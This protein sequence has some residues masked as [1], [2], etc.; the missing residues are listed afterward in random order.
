M[1]RALASD[2][3]PLLNWSKIGAA[4]LPTTLLGYGITDAVRN[5][6]G[7]VGIGTDSP[8]ASLDLGA[9]TDAVILAQGTTAQQPTSPVEG[10]FRYNKTSKRPEFFDGT[11]WVTIGGVSQPYSP[12]CGL[13]G[14][15]SSQQLSTITISA[16][17]SVQFKAW[18]AGGARPTDRAGVAGGNG[19]GGGFATVTIGPHSVDTTYYISIGGGGRTNSGSTP[20]PGGSGLTSYTGGSGSGP[21]GYGDPGA[22]GGASTAI[23]TGS[24][25]G[26]VVLVGAGGGG[27]GG[28][29][30]AYGDTTP[31]RPGIAGGTP[32]GTYVT[33]TAGGNGT[34]PGG[35]GGGT[36]GGGSG[37]TQGGA[38]GS[39]DGNG[40]GN[41]GFGGMNYAQSGG[42][43]SAG[44]GSMPGSYGDPSRP[45]NAGEGATT[46]ASSGRD[47]AIWYQSY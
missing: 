33:G 8:K 17:C 32:G 46:A 14:S 11:Q 6:G 16:G 35:F 43:V 21:G 37:Y 13:T 7:R 41:G 39:T 20:G 30:N 45:A 10:M 29:T 5:I 15:L 28:T 26:G 9:N 4:T 3:I 44:G 25:G 34:F 38:A 1:F 24:Y 18:G 27:G 22:G 23:F 42:A 19:G 31:G 12:S 36:G 47:G 40:P 2:D